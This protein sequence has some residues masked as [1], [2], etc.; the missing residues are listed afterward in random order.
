VAVIREPSV[1]E[2]L[3]AHGASSVQVSCDPVQLAVRK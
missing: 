2:P 1:E 3:I